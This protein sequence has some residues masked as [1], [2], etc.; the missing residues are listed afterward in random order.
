MNQRV[1]RR[2]K[3]RIVNLKKFI[4]FIISVFIIAI[5]LVFIFVKNN[6]A[7]S[8]TYKEDYNEIIVG[9][10]DTLWNIAVKNM[11][12]KYDVRK[13]VYEIMEFNQM[14]NAYIYPGDLIKIPIKHNPKS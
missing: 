7:Y 10:G 5:I 3:Y 6:E 1:T 13:M 8:S 14:E 11:P 9:E 2:K 12:D 4:S